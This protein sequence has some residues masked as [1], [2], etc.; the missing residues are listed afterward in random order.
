MCVLLYVCVYVSKYIYV[1]VIW[2]TTY[3]IT[4]RSCRIVPIGW[5]Y[6]CKINQ[7]IKIL[8]WAVRKNV[9][10]HRYSLEAIYEHAGNMVSVLSIHR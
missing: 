7:E 3:S 4:T 5:L 1:F 8:S 10:T 6:V 2:Y 9:N